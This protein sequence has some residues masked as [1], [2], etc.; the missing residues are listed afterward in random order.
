MAYTSDLVA[1]K[2]TAGLKAKLLE[3]VWRKPTEFGY[4]IYVNALTGSDTTGDGSQ[5]K[6]FATI[7]NSMVWLF[8]NF[9]GRPNSTLVIDCLTDLDESD[10]YFYVQYFP[11]L[12]KIRAQGHSVRMGRVTVQES[13]F[14]A[15]GVTFVHKSGVRCV[16]TNTHATIVLTDCTYESSG[17]QSF[18]PFACTRHSYMAIDGLT[19]NNPDC[20]IAMF[21]A[22]LTGHIGVQGNVTI[23]G[24][25]GTGGAFCHVLENSGISITNATFTGEWTGKKYYLDASSVLYAGRKGDDFIPGNSAGTIV[26]EFSQVI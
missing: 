11:H 24:A 3:N 9:R 20:S 14:S 22:S 10:V 13:G 4:H 17:S 18:T 23:N 21:L 7:T 12:L 25:S 1:D 16:E 19:I 5:E 26:D 15:E 8:D 2:V 6:P